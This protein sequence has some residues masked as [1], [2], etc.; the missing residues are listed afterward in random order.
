[1]L[2]KKLGHTGKAIIQYHDIGDYLSREDKL[3]IIAEKRSILNPAMNWTHI[4]PNAQGD[5]LNQRNDIFGSFIP[6]GDK[7]DKD[8]KQT[9][10]VPYYSSGLKT[11]RD[12]W[13]YNF[14][15]ARFVSFHSK[16]KVLGQRSDTVQQFREPGQRSVPR[17]FLG[18]RIGRG[19]PLPM[20]S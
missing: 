15:Q 5:W 14:S 3:A 8:N 4:R 20:L 1:M 7:D 9:F 19:A 11:Q 16:C 18:G 6:L 2:V 17:F 12:A 13:C 10:F